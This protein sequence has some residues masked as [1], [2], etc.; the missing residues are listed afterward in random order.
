MHP[1]TVPA[2]TATTEQVLVSVQDTVWPYI[3]GTC[4][5]AWLVL[6][7]V[8]LALLMIILLKLYLYNQWD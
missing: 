6:C 2:E 7:M 5:D 8:E 3:T 4:V 1:V